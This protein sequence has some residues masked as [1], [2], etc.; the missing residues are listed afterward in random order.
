MVPK[1]EPCDIFLM[2]LTAPACFGIG[3][4]AS[5]SLY[6]LLIQ[7]VKPLGSAGLI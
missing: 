3:T 2:L 5:K 7:L 6:L 1:G 4:E